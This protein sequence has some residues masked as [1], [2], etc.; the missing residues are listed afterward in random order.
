M[1]TDPEVLTLLS[2]GDET[3]SSA[4][5]LAH[6]EQ[7]PVCAA[8]LRRFREVVAVART[9][10][11]G[12]TLETPR[13]QVWDAIRAELGLDPEFT[14]H[15]VPPPAAEPTTRPH[16]AAVPSSPR[17]PPSAVSSGF[18]D[19]DR[20]T[21]SGSARR[22]RARASGR[23]FPR[24][25]T[26][27]IAAALAL[28]VGVTGTL[29]AQRALQPAD[30]VIAST[31]LAAL[32][33]WA[34]SSGTAELERDS[35]GRRWLVV[36]VSTSRSVDGFQQVW[37]MNTDVTAMLQVGLLSQPQQRFPLPAGVDVEA[38]PVVD[39]S[40]EPATDNGAHSGN[41]IVRGTLPT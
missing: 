24:F 25:L 34:G 38:Y 15:L 35:D 31:P 18:T 12:Y 10:T 7:C 37:L 28:V 27:A 17:T 5:D 8:E 6:I 16:L 29:L 14:S 26:L 30:T 33:D 3:G 36:T 40:D 19:D 1:H 22:D 13:P 39:V 32:P 4:A 41:S 9:V 23:T 2:L 11:D 20:Q 21:A